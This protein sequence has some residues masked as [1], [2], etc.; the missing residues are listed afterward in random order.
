MS[1]LL[2]RIARILSQSSTTESDS[3]ADPEPCDVPITTAANLMKNQRR[4]LAVALVNELGPMRLRALADAVATIADDNRKSVYCTL[5]Q[6]HLPKLDVHDVIDIGER[7]HLVE[8]GPNFD[9]FVDFGADL[10]ERFDGESNQ[11]AVV[12]FNEDAVSAVSD[13]VSE[14]GGGA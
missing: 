11:T 4:R 3:A 14:V 6:N 1:G 12:E 5:Y 9:A 8:P 13:D 10:E 7:G 2:E